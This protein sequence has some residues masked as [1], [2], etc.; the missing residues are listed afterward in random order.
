M[1]TCR[2]GRGSGGCAH[3]DRIGRKMN[4]PDTKYAKTSD[5]LFVAYQVIGEGPVD[6]LLV[7][8]YMSNLELNWD[9]P[10]FA[11]LL[12]R[13]ASFCRLVV[14]DRRGT[15][16]SDHLSPG[17]HPPLETLMDDVSACCTTSARSRPPW[18]ASSMAATCVRSSPRPIRNGLAR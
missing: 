1:K 12:R 8:G 11:N 2:S 14:V 6:L 3:E 10:A 5:G 15:G 9:L 17:E 16:L 7:P 4:V 18:R 13:L